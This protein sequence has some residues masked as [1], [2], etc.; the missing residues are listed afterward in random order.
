MTS[1]QHAHFQAP[2]KEFEVLLFAALREAAAADRILV[3]VPVSEVDNQGGND[4]TLTVGDLLAHCG[5]Q[6]PVLLPWLPYTKVAV[7]CAYAGMHQPVRV[8]DEIA[9]LPP[10]AGGAV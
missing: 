3:R 2:E 6:Y 5:E 9:L 4:A 7:N 10:V 8:G 1:N